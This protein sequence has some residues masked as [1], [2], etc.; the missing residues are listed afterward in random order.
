MVLACPAAKTNLTCKRP[1]TT[2]NHR[3]WSDS[4][5]NALGVMDWPS[6]ICKTTPIGHFLIVVSV[7]KEISKASQNLQRMMLSK[8]FRK[9]KIPVVWSIP[10]V[11]VV[12][13]SRIMSILIIQHPFQHIRNATEWQYRN[14]CGHSELRWAKLTMR[15]VAV[16]SPTW[17]GLRISRW[18]WALYTLKTM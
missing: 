2:T 4:S 16:R 11:V 18:N 6:G 13:L 17:R 10:G 1:A 5:K 3:N 7:M 14:V 8:H 12:I 9:C 15:K